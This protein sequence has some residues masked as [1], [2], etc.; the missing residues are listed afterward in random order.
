MT[1]TNFTGRAQVSD[2]GASGVAKRFYRASSEAVM[3]E[4]KAPR[5]GGRRRNHADRIKSDAFGPFKSEH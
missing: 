2:F 5:A 1:L 3:P 4:G